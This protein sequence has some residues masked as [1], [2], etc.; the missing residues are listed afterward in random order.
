MLHRVLFLTT[1]SP[2]CLCVCVI[3][4]CVFVLLADPVVI[5]MFVYANLLYFPPFETID[6]LPTL[7]QVNGSKW[8]LFDTN[9]NSLLK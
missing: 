8:R 6:P 4:L 1:T 2:I 9:D 3:F 7:C 5:F